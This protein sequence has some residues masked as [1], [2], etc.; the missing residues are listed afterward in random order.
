MSAGRLP[1]A[2]VPFPRV[3]GTTAQAEALAG[4]IR[5][6]SLAPFPATTGPGERRVSAE[7]QRGVL[8]VLAE[9]ANGAGFCFLTIATIE[10]ESGWNT[11]TV[12]R[13]LAALESQALV[14]RYTYMRSPDRY[15]PSLPRRARQ[16]QGPS[17]YRMGRVLRDAAGLVHVEWAPESDA[18]SPAVT[19]PLCHPRDER[20]C[21]P[22][23]ASTEE[24]ARGTAD[25][26]RSWHRRQDT[27]V[28]PERAGFF[29][30]RGLASC[31]P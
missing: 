2:R 15:R 26:T 6:L 8:T 23:D 7:A 5:Q 18:F 11:R 29:R 1:L 12:Q 13:A 21:H 10:H 14:E 31:H 16:G 22:R 27:R 28:T 25:K 24:R 17:I 30:L 19:S 9:H 20:P 4:A 3:K